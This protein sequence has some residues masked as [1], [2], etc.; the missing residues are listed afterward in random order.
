MQ[1]IQRMETLLCQDHTPDVDQA[2]I[3]QI[4]PPET[5]VDKPGYTRFVREIKK[6][7]HSGIGF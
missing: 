4:H 3:T 2:P 1:E 7:I 6:Y 5:N